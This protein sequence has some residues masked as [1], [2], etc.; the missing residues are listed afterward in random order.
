MTFK[1]ICD[2][3][4]QIGRRAYRGNAEKIAV[5]HTAKKKFSNHNVEVIYYNWAIEALKNHDK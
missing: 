3:C 1:I 2:K 5:R 4:G